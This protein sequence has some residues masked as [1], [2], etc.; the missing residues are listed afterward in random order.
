MGRTASIAIFVLAQ[1]V[2]VVGVDL[3][4]FR[5]RFWERLMVNVGMPVCGV[6]LRDGEPVGRDR[7]VRARA[8]KTMTRGCPCFGRLAFFISGTFS[9]TALGCSNQAA[10]AWTSRGVLVAGRNADHA[11]LALRE[12][13]R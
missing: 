4:F 6:G 9:G 12:A 3:L 2:L 7:P 13:P 11:E 10:S 5:N 1:I 8:T